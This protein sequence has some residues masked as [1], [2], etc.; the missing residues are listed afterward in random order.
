MVHDEGL[1]GKTDKYW[2]GVR[3]RLDP[4][5]VFFSFFFWSYTWPLTPAKS[6]CMPF[7]VG[8][9]ASG[10]QSEHEWEINGRFE[11]AVFEQFSCKQKWQQSDRP[12]IKRWHTT[13]G[14]VRTVC[15]REKDRCSATRLDA[16]TCMQSCRS[17][18]EASSVQ[19]RSISALGR[20]TLGT[21]GNERLRT[22]TDLA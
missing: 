19:F 15:R 20:M 14:A 2:H 3:K 6:A 22:C 21:K 4:D 11:R 9:P 5:G 7:S 1:T 13:Q 16:P 17:C 10:C 12:V 8:A 18:V